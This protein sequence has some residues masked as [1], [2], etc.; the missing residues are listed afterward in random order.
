MLAAAATHL[1]P[2]RKAGVLDLVSEE[3]EVLP[4]VRLIAAPGHT[5]GHAAIE[6]SSD[7]ETA[8]WLADAL[9]HEL[10]FAR[11]ELLSVTDVDPELTVRTRGALLERAA[12]EGALVGGFHLPRVGRVQA[13][14]DAYQF[15][16]EPS[17]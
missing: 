13:A 8:L 6:V 5:P 3:T 14:G 4:G 10:N 15:V 9:L 7:G 1:P 11:P 12:A 16:A 2:L 17:S